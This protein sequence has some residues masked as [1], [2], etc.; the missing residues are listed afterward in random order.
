[1]VNNLLIKAA[2]IAKKKKQQ[3]KDK[4]SDNGEEGPL[5]TANLA[6]S[7]KVTRILPSTAKSLLQKLQIQQDQNNKF[8]KRKEK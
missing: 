5:Q 3:K 1:M 6:N 2:N 7:A 4:Q 8:S